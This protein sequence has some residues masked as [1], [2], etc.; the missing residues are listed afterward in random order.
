MKK[1][2]RFFKVAVTVSKNLSDATRLL[3]WASGVFQHAV[4]SFPN[5]LFGIQK[6]DLPQRI[7]T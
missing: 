3:N 5:G 7:E 2:A 1:A 6:P 4:D